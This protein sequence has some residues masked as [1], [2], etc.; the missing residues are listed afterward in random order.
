MASSTG[1]RLANKFNFD[2]EH[3]S[4]IG[5]MKG[6]VDKSDRLSLLLGIQSLSNQFSHIKVRADLLA[7]KIDPNFKKAP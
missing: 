6:P 3:G 2:M 7:G 5:K 1:S 4:G